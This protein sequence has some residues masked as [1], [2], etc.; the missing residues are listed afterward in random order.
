M[1]REARD[2][3]SGHH[4]REVEGSGDTHV[5]VLEA[6]RVGF[7]QRWP[8]HSLPGSL[9]R[10]EVSVPT[11]PG[12]FP[13]QLSRVIWNTVPGCTASRPSR[14][15]RPVSCSIALNAFLVC[16]NEQN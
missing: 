9:A 7:K 4:A 13:G 15:A 14:L 16:F 2:T 8:A 11:L 10:R 5:S 1:P 12:V 3:E 6:S